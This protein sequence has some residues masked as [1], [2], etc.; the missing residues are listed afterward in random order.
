MA[1]T[2]LT[3][4]EIDSFNKNGYL[5]LENYLK[6]EKVD[7]LKKEIKRVISNYDFTNFNHIFTCTEKGISEKTLHDEYFFESWDKV[8]FFLELDKTANSN[9]PV[10][11]ENKKINKIGHN[12]HNLLEPFKKVSFDSSVKTISQQLG[13]KKPAIC[14]SMY[15]FKSPRIGSAVTPHQDATFL[16][17]EPECRILGFWIA[18][19]DANQENGCLWAIPGSHNHGLLNNVRFV[20]DPSIGEFAT[21]LTPEYPVFEH[22]KYVPIEVQKGSLVLI[23]G[24][25][26]HKSLPNTSEKPRDIYTWHIVDVDNTSWHKLNWIQPPNGIS[27]FTL[28]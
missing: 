28:I 23:H 22:D 8:G 27:D 2:I 16:W 20:R 6:D 11:N 9:D 26:M 12:L 21:K 5:V 1:Q 15:I 19:E 10:T 3:E 7:E 13:F 17:T 14:Q 24:Y 18:L 4:Q 25:V